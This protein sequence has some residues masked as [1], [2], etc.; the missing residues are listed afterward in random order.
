MRVRTPQD[1]GLTIR[2]RRIELG[3]D[4]TELAQRVGVSRQ[5]LVAIEKGKPRAEIGL[6]LRTLRELD[7]DVW[8][9]DLP[10]SDGRS[11]PAI[12]LN[13]V[14]DRARGTTDGD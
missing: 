14:L 9:G 8:V 4:Q 3:M 1:I 13:R 6:V 12:D 11:A 7:L 2:E 5:W 10:A